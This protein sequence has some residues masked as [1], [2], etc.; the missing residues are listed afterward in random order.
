MKIPSFQFD[1]LLAGANEMDQHFRGASLE[2]NLPVQLGIWYRNFFGLQS[3]LVA[4]Y[5]EALHFL[6]SYLQ[7][8]E[9][10]SNGKSARLDGAMVDHSTS[11][12]TWGAPG[13]NG[14][15]AFFQMLHQ[16]PTIVPIDFIAVLTP[17][18]PFASP[19]PETASQLLCAKRGADAWTHARGSS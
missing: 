17:A 13:T 11:A 6:P 7:Q 10:E 15:H 8:L 2:T 19:P 9:M 16:G 4:P 18:H 5:P 14:Q 1:E 3:Y 12:V